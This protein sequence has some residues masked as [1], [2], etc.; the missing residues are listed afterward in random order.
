MPISF[1][2]PSCGSKV[3]APDG[4]AGRVF[5]CPNCR[6]PMTVPGMVD[7][8]TTTPA[9]LPAVVAQPPPMVVAEPVAPC[10]FCGESILQ[11]A[12][13]CR[14]CGEILDPLL[15]EQLAQQQAPQQP[16]QVIQVITHAHAE[17][18]AESRSKATVSTG[19]GCLAILAAAAI[20]GA[21]L[22]RDRDRPIEPPAQQKKEKEK[23]PKAKTAE[24]GTEKSEGPLKDAEGHIVAT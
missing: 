9:S 18:R 15:R 14:Y 20:F 8:P 21:F 6:A 1:R 13:K 12:K 3:K 5:S 23:G 4:A 16:Q 19:C 7:V 24:S 2:C 10:P 17:A 22:S 11:V